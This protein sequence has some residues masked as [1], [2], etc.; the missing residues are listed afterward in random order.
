M[1]VCIKCGCHYEDRTSLKQ[2]LCWKCEISEY[3]KSSAYSREVG[4]IQLKDNTDAH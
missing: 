1:K 4:T 3:V 2:Q